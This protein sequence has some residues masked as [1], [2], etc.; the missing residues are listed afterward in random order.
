MTYLIDTSWAIAYLRNNREA[1]ERLRTFESEGVAASIIIVAELFR[2][3][4]LS[5]DPVKG[6]GILQDFLA[7][8]TI[9][10]INH[11]IAK[12]FGREDAK[13]RREGNPIG[14][15]DLLIAPQLLGQHRLEVWVSDLYSAQRNHPAEQWQVCLAHQLRDYQFAI[16]AGDRVFAPVMKRVL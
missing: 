10:G 8:V 16:E 2:G 1:Q 7:G 4:F 13:L 3:V 9:L 5:N 15:L 11:E 6:E 12:V 14:H